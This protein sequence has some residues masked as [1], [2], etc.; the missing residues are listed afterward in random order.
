MLLVRLGM[1]VVAETGRLPV[2]NP[3]THLELTMV[4]EAMV[5]EYAGPD[6]ALVELASALRHPLSVGTQRNLEPGGVVCRSRAGSG[7]GHS[8]DGNHP[9]RQRQPVL[10]SAQIKRTSLEPSTAHSISPQR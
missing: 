3:S 4:H 7:H 1:V 10:S 5:L 9:H 8:I 2:D 6:L